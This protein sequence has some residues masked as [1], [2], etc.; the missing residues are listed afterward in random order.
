VHTDY[1]VEMLY[2]NGV[3]VI[4]DD[5]F[6]NGLRF[7]GTE[8]WAFCSR[9]SVRVTASDPNAPETDPNKGPLRASDKKILEPLKHG[10]RWAPS[11]NHYLN[12]LESIAANRQP[13]APIDQAARSLTACAAAWIGMKLKRKLTWN[14][15]KEMFVNDDEA[16]AMRERKPRSSEYDFRRVMSEAGLSA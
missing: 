2:A 15:E 16:N 10:K 12:W 5:K 4:L 9:G 13:I 1:H 3:Q 6:E 11:S 8:G 14:P 7:E